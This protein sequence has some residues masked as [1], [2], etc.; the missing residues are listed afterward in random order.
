MYFCVDQDNFIVGS[1]AV[2]WYYSKD[3]EPAFL[4]RVKDMF[5]YH[6]GS[7]IGGSLI[8]GFFYFVDLTFDFFCVSMMIVSLTINL[9]SQ[10]RMPMGTTSPRN[11][12]T[13]STMIG[14]STTLTLTAAKI[15]S[16]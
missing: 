6:L 15:S 9:I 2:Y 8:Q 13:L 4:D 16:T 11:M 10:S 1:H 12:M 7:V 14:P 3:G 5:L